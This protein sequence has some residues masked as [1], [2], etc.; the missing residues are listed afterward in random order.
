MNI[1]DLGSLG[2]VVAAA[3]T[4]IT[5]VYLA[6]QIRQNSKTQIVN[7]TFQALDPTWDF[8]FVPAQSPQ[9]TTVAVKGLR[10]FHNLNDE[11]RLQFV[12]WCMA[13]LNAYDNLVGLYEIGMVPDETLENA[14]VS[15]GWF[16]RSP[17]LRQYSKT[18]EGPRSK[19]LEMYLDRFIGPPNEEL[20]LPK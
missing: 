16:F 14:L 10:D 12:M 13:I 2:E 1:Q 15:A 4:V 18:R 6:L 17:G 19:K 11:E 7:A 5:L 8:A 9:L 3:A 20:D